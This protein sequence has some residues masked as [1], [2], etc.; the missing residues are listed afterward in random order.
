MFILPF[1]AQSS[2]QGLTLN[3]S[4]LNG[5]MQMTIWRVKFINSCLDYKNKI[6]AVSAG[7]EPLGWQCRSMLRKGSMWLL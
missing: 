3:V 7:L 5:R 6:I 2:V 1:Y 4:S